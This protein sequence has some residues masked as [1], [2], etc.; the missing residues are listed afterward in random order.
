MKL[1][2]LAQRHTP[3]SLQSPLPPTAG[4]IVEGED[5]QSFLQDYALC[6]PSQRISI[7]SMF[8][9][10]GNAVKPLIEHQGYPQLTVPNNKGGRAVLLWI[11][12][13]APTTRAIKAAIDQDGRD[14]ALPWATAGGSSSFEK[15]NLPTASPEDMGGSE[16]VEPENKGRSS[17][18]WI[19]TFVDENEA[20]RFVRA[21]HKRPFHLSGDAVR[22]ADAALVNTEFLW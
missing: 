4:T 5:A 9:P 12:G 11:D 6:P 19:V 8:A 13:H 14:R 7:T 18:R 16:A 10:F 15:L 2:K 17:A 20:R 22:G 1:H 21:W 3:I